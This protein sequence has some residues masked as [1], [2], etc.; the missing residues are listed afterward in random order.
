MQM[1]QA[2]IDAM[3]NSLLKTEKAPSESSSREGRGRVRVYDFRRP[4][5][6]SK[7]QMRTLQMVHDNYA[8]LIT[9][10]FSANFRTMV[11]I[12]VSSVDQLTYEQYLRGVAAPAVL[13][14]VELEPLPGNAILELTNSIA[15]PIIDRL[16]GGPGLSL[17]AVRPLTEIEQT[18]MERVYSGLLSNLEE[19][20]RNLFEF[21][22]RLQMI[23]VNPLFAQIVP[24]SEIVVVISMDVKLGEHRGA[25]NLCLPYLL[26][27]P[28][29]PK[30]SAHQWF[31]GNRQQLLPERQQ[32][33][34]NLAETEVDLVVRLGSTSLT[35]R[36]FL[37]LEVGDVVELDTSI[38]SPVE[39]LVGG[40]VKFL[41]RVGRV[42]RRLAF[43]AEKVLS[44]GEEE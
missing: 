29:I 17:V 35:I 21:R 10:F 44:E 9:T 36:D 6:F 7:D 18:A 40:K 30:L 22:A 20:W 38:T 25:I 5:K 32:L 23:E 42:G 12:A 16:F 33:E 31:A 19:A 14:I 24:P 26:L 34:K 27:E 8:R 3:I 11:Q 43:R 4:D 1:S 37:G 41:G 28:L 15:F 13:G 2:E 39:L